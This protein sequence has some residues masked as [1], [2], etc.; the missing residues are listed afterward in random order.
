MLKVTIQESPTFLAL[1]IEGRLCSDWASEAQRAWSQAIESAGPR[2][3][4]VDLSGV[5]FVDA[6]GEAFLAAAIKDG[7][8]MRADGLLV[9][10]LVRKLQQHSGR[11]SSPDSRAAPGPHRNPGAL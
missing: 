2:E 7:A 10:H 11:N 6:T 4:V 5:T 9:G 1:L 3:L 8:T